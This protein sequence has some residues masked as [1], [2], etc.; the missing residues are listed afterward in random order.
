MSGEGDRH[1]VSRRRSSFPPVL[2][3]VDLA[4]LLGLPSERSARNWL[5][6]SGVPFIRDG[7]RAIVLLDEVIA[8][9]KTRS[10]PGG[11]PSDE[12]V[13]DTAPR[14]REEGGPA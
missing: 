7:Q 10:Y 9:L 14:A 1:P 12:E 4:Q 6:R 2:L 13:A 11:T 3:P 5:R 8:H